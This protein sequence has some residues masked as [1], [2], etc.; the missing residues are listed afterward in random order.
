MIDYILC[1]Y[2]YVNVIPI[3]LM[4]VNVYYDNW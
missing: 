3:A 4:V 1:M 2:V